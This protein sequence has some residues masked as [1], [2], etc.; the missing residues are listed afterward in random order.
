MSS[1]TLLAEI[2][3][4]PEE[5]RCEVMAF[6]SFLKSRYSADSP[7]GESMLSLAESAWAADWSSPEEDEAWKDL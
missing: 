6:L 3:S 5:I 1:T 2:E 4:A 7:T